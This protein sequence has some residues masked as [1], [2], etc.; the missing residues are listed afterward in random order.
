MI[1]DKSWEISKLCLVLNWL[2]NLPLMPRTRARP[3]HKTKRP[4][5]PSLLL[6]RRSILAMLSRDN[7]TAFYP[8]LPPNEMLPHAHASH[9]A[10]NALVIDGSKSF[11]GNNNLQPAGELG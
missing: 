4:W 11:S 2:C 9:S 5:R 1:K 3:R 6:A 7:V 8:L 10:H